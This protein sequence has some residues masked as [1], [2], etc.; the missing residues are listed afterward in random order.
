MS[1][2]I[3]LLMGIFGCAMFLVTAAPWLVYVIITAIEQVLPKYEKR[4]VEEE[5]EAKVDGIEEILVGSGDKE[6]MRPTRRAI[7][8]GIKSGGERINPMS[9]V[10]KVKKK[11]RR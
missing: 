7:R 11:D 6:A 2:E 5:A 1:D 8:R 4:E 9:R 10:T 3:L